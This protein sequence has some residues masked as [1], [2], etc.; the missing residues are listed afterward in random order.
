VGRTGISFYECPDSLSGALRKTFSS[1]PS[2]YEGDQWYQGDHMIFALNQ[3][4]AVAFISEKA[5]E[6]MREIV[7]TE[8]DTVNLVDCLKLAETAF[9]LKEMAMAL[10]EMA[11]TQNG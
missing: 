3:I 2:F 9:V 5:D 7:H 8:K 1:K 4:P 6:L 11:K 10:R